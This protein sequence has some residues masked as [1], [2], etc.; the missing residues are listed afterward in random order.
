MSELDTAETTKV[1]APTPP[2]QPD[3]PE[4]VGEPKEAPEAD[5][6][7]PPTDSAPDDTADPEE[8][9]GPADSADPE[10]DPE[11][12]DDAEP[13][14][15]E[16]LDASTEPQAS[17]EAATDGAEDAD[18]ADAGASD[19]AAVD[20]TVDE[21]AQPDE[22]EGP[23]APAEPEA[24]AAADGDEGGDA[25][26]GEPEAPEGEEPPERQE[27]SGESEA[28]EEPDGSVEQDTD[29]VEEHDE[30]EEA[31]EVVEE[32]QGSTEED[33]PESAE[34]AE[35]EEPDAPAEGEA[36]DAPEAP[37]ELEE[38]NGDLPEL[39]LELKPY[40]DSVPYSVEYTASLSAEQ[41]AEASKKAPE[42]PHME[43]RDS[44]SSDDTAD[45]DT[46]QEPQT[47]DGLAEPEPEP[48][49]ASN[50]SA[51]DD[52]AE[53]QAESADAADQA[54]DPVEVRKQE[55]L[56][57]GLIDEAGRVPVEELESGD[58]VRG[59]PCDDTGYEIRG[60]DLEYLGLDEKQ[61]EAWQRFEAPL[62]MSPEQFKEFKSSLNDA[63]AADGIDADQVDLR[64][65][66]SSAQFFSGSHKDFPTEE[67]LADQ[68][69][70]L[71]RLTE[72]M[73]DRTESERPSRIPFDAKYRMGVENGDGEPEE[74]SD[75]DVQ[76]SSDSM[77]EKATEVWE[78]ADP[79]ER[80]PEVIHPKYQFVD[81]ATMREAFPELAA[82]AKSWEA[83]TGREVAPALFGA[84]GPPDQTNVGSGISAHFRETDWIINRPGGDRDE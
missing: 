17:A 75:Y 25:E 5:R 81:K 70:A 60:E 6:V 43:R 9:E 32:P 55:A 35:P 76:I 71:S 23:D 67:D 84:D 50:D 7:G 19:D 38:P 8:P 40:R 3:T 44:A 58:R 41:P 64:L 74:P 53:Y 22:P 52:S 72:W 10:A 63:L 20:A 39:E 82:W 27:V 13:D 11:S 21:D 48:A 62:G 51:T 36:A 2:P 1:D 56:A 15:P 14:E 61:V 45:P 73:G 4:P 65:Q 79:A 37:G 31:G 12:A 24:S 54:G 26:P 33:S 49:E 83:E 77:V 29:A 59:W 80:K 28:Q 30:S 69:E 16:D 66:G 46:L 68:P 47:S 34:T 78:A 18:A 57:N 42:L